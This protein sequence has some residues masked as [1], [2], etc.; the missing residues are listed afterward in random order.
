MYVDDS[1]GE[2]KCYGYPNIIFH[3]RSIAAVPLVPDAVMF[4]FRALDTF[5]LKTA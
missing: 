2:W 1:I 3:F 4:L 5:N